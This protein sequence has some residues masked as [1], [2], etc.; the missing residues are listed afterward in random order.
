MVQ[1]KCRGFNIPMQTWQCRLQGWTAIVLPAVCPHS[2]GI[3]SREMQTN[4]YFVHI[5]SVVTDN[6]PSWISRLEEKGRKNDFMINLRKSMG[7][8]RNGT[9]DPW[10]CSQT[11]VR[12]LTDCTTQPRI[13]FQWERLYFMSL[14][15]DKQADIIIIFFTVL[16]GIKIKLHE[17]CYS[18]NCK[19]R[20]WKYNP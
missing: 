10:I 17:L 2:V 6:N 12:R 15:Y 7:Q 20:T 18:Q 16:K 13:L 9:S 5:L 14:T 1:E 4:Q 19:M 8:G 11:V 3:N